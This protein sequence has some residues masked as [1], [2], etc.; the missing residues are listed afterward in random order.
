MGRKPRKDRRARHGRAEAPA[1]AR[2]PGRPL[3]FRTAALQGVGRRERQ[4][5]ACAL[6]NDRD[7]ALLREQGL[8]CVVADG[9][10]GMEGGREA[11]ETAVATL[12]DA[13]RLFDR[14]AELAAQLNGAL[15]TANEAVF[16]RLGGKGGSTAVVCLIRDEKL[17]FSSVGDSYL[18][19]LRGGRLLR[20]NRSQNVL[21]QIWLEMIRS[22]ES[23]FLSA[24]REPDR[25]AITGFLGM[26]AL[27][28]IDFFRRPLRLEAGDVLLVCSDGVGG[29]LPAPALAGC[30]SEGGPEEAAEALERWIKTCDLSYQDNY[31]AL[32]VQCVG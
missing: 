19:L 3:V 30:L 23:D 1:P 21:H 25:D 27:D 7:P 26:R 16:R 10:G 29:V 11:S 6:V 14:G 5:D 2:D 13:F 28:E 31:T 20:L 22:G 32:V 8:L 24:L 18:F 12:L 17:Y 9:M 15:R 4:E